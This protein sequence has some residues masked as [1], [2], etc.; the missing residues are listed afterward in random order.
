MTLRPCPSRQLR[1]W[2]LLV[3]LGAGLISLLLP[4]SWVGHLALSALVLA[5]AAYSDW[6]QVRQ[7]APWSILA[8]QCNAQ[9]WELE[10]AS[11]RR[12]STRLLASSFIGQRLMVLNFAWKPWWALSLPLFSDSL[13]ADQ[14]RQLRVHLNITAGRSEMS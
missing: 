12:V 6:V 1:G 10:L 5:Q 2:I 11:G 9:G 14:L 4:L 7:R 8:V 13:Q 3:A